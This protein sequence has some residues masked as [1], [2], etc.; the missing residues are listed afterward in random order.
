[1]F[2]LFSFF[3]GIFF[4]LLFFFLGDLCFAAAVLGGM[5]FTDSVTPQ[6]ATPPPLCVCVCARARILYYMHVYVCAL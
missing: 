1:M 5:R 4:H 6:I 3:P 2:F